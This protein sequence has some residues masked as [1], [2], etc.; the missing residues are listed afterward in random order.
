M[1]IHGNPWQSIAIHGNQG[2]SG[3]I[4]AHQRHS[5]LRPA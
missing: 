3:A 1:A 5:R 2:P 4:S